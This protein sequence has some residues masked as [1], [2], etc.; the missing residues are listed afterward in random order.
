MRYEKTTYKVCYYLVTQSLVKGVTK[1]I[2]GTCLVPSQA[3]PKE[4]IQCKY[5]GF[6]VWFVVTYEDY[7]PLFTQIVFLFEDPLVVPYNTVIETG[8]IGFF[9]FSKSN[10]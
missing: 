1:S 8:F 6:E 2:S 7:V 3:I 9:D 5:P 4:F 10:F